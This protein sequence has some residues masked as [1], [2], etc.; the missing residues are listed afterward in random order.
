[1]SNAKTIIPATKGFSRLCDIDS[2]ALEPV[3]A[4]AIDDDTLEVTAIYLTGPESASD[5]IL[6]PN[7]VLVNSLGVFRGT[8]AF[9]EYM[10]EC[11]GVKTA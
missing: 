10:A 11:A 8:K 9:A 3:I 4:W 6:C 7:G 5:G 1:M 2:R